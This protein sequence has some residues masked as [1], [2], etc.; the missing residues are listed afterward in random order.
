[1]TGSWW[2]QRFA[3]EGSAAAEGIMKQLGQPL[4]DPLTVLVREAA[5]NSWD[6]RD[7]SGPVEF[8]IDIRRIGE[9]CDAW[10]GRLLP[11]PAAE[12]GINLEECL[13]PDSHLLVVSDRRT[14][15]LG[16][17]LRAGQREATGE[18]PD[19]VQFVRN[20]GEPSDHEF[21]GGTYGF[22]KGIFYRLS[23]AATILVDTMT[24]S[25]GQSRRRLMGAA[26]GHSWFDGDQRYTGRHWWGSIAADDVP[27]PLLGATADAVAGELGL[28]DF[29]DGRTGTNIVIVGADLGVT[30]DEPELRRRTPEEAATFLASSILWHLWPK[31][32]P[33]G[34]GRSMTF[35]VAVDGHE[36]VVPSPDELDEFRPFVESLSVLR[37]GQGIPHTRTIPPRESG[38]FALSLAS[39]GSGPTRRLVSAARPF[40]G[41]ARHVARMRV[42]ELIVDYVPGPPHPDPLLRYGGVF[43]ASE[44]ADRA[45][46]AAE[47]PTHDDWVEKGLQGT[48]RG[49]VQGARR[50]VLRQIEDA[51]GMGAPA[52]GG[53]GEG[54]GELSARLAA[55]VPTVSATG[56]ASFGGSESRGGTS[57][58]TPSHGRDS[59]ARAGTSSRG[60]E[61]P[62]L[63]GAPTLQLNDGLPFLAARVHIPES[64]ETR[65][66]QAEVTVVVEGGG[67]ESEPPVGALIPAITQWLPVP[68]GDVVN[69]HTLTLPAGHTC[70]WWVYA[71]YVPDAVVRF[72]VKRVG[73]RAS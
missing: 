2:S 68:G 57:G 44:G 27:D 72:R 62:R 9:R 40:E 73:D 48:V 69:G 49:V 50:F 28:P 59:S 14:V 3:P 31:F 21:G 56:A 5:Q 25:V 13:S 63:V 60:R 33:D 26:L 67:R 54:L 1:V 47:P 23:D 70:D 36:V 51:L 71:T 22:G 4:L 35:A 65:H 8:R 12:T 7:G 64:T 30:G 58:H 34:E 55:L 38:R 17:P 39:A 43:K 42:A 24:G 18:S 53:G 46:A 20:V 29:A 45:F 11:L 6:A 10:R 66:I 52:V 61:G 32:F 19:F 16:G 37:E 41:P 15:G